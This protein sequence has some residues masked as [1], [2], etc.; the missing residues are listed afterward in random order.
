[1]V[2][3]QLV[4]H[5][6]KMSRVKFMENF[7]I[8]GHVC[9][10]RSIVEQQQRSSTARAHIFCRSHYWYAKFIRIGNIVSYAEE[11]SQELTGTRDLSWPR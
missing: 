1:M 5:S 3:A 7:L 4:P 6:P 2:I 9:L 10:P 11:E 8:C